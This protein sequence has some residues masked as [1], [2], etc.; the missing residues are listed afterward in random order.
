MSSIYSRFEN[1]LTQNPAQPTNPTGVKREAGDLNDV[2]DYLKC[3]ISD[4]LMEDPVII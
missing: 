4:E 1:Y 2:P 3:R